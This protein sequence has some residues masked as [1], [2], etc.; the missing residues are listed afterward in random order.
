[1][2]KKMNKMIIFVLLLSHWNLCANEDKPSMHVKYV[3]EIIH[4]FAEDMERELE[5]VC[6]GSGGSMPYDV[7]SISMKFNTYQRAT[8][9]Q[10]CELEVKA[11]EKLLK[12]INSHPKIRPYLRVYPFT[13]PRAE[14]AISFYKS[15]GTPYIDGIVVGH[16]FQ[17]RGYIFYCKRSVEG[18]LSDLGEEPYEVAFNI[19]QNPHLHLKHDFSRR[20]SNTKELKLV[21]NPEEE[22]KFLRA[23][24]AEPPIKR[25]ERLKQIAENN[26]LMTLSEAIRELIVGVTDPYF[27]NDTLEKIASMERTQNTGEYVEYW[28]N[29]QIKVSAAFKNGWADGHIH[30]WYENGYDAFKGYFSEGIK[31]GVHMVFFPPQRCGKPFVNEGRLL[32]YDEIGKPHGSQQTCYPKRGLESFMKY[33]HGTI[34]G[35][36]GIYADDYNGLLEERKYERGKLVETKTY[37]P[38]RIAAKSK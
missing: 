19:A 27:V 33:N 17:V 1:M 18:H 23:F 28:D 11:T 4:S 26:S 24:D 38:K 8:I 10:A 30:G 35:K 2:E 9:D 16:V 6:I 32:S 25:W 29:G 15:N 37:P 3:N 14:V 31:Q 36:M 22:E 5:L 13:A 21:L 20:W 34:D 12:A 7:E